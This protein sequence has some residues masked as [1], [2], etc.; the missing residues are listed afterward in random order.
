MTSYR[1]E[2]LKDYKTVAPP[3]KYMKISLIYE[4]FGSKPV[5]LYR[6]ELDE[7]G[8]PLGGHA[9]AV[10]NQSNGS[11]E[12]LK[13]YMK[14]FKQKHAELEPIICL[15]IQEKPDTLGLIL[16]YFPKQ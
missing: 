11:N 9:I 4:T 5:V 2:I 15:H 8:T 13:E 10:H 1:G 14:Q 6:C 12:G 16:K 7:R 3:Q